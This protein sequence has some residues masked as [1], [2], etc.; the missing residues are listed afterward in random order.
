MSYDLQLQI[1]LQLDQGSASKLRR[2]IEN[3]LSGISVKGIDSKNFSK[4]NS[5]INETGKLLD[6]GAKKAE[7]FFDRVEGKARGF[8]AYAIAS[9]SII[10][11]TGA[12][13]S[14]TREAIKYETELLKIAQVTGDTIDRT[15][16]YSASLVDIST[17]YNVTLSKVAQLTRTLTQTGLSFKEASKGAEI[18]AR[19]SLLATFDSLTSTTEG[20][21]AVMQTFEFSVSRAG[22]VLE[23]INAVS[24]KFA[25][26]SGDIVEAIRRTGGAFSSAGGQIEELIALFTAVRSTSRETAETIA[27]GFRT[28]FGRLQRPKTIEFFKDLNIELQDLEGNFIGPYQAIER[29]SKGLEEA[30]IRAGSLRFAEVVEQIG[31]IRQ[32]SRVV[33]LLEEV[34]K[35][36][37]ALDIANNASIESIEDLEKAQAGL[38]FRLGQ[39]KQEFGALIAEIVNS[40]SLEFLADVFINISKSVIELTKALKP[41][42]PILSIIATYKIGRGLTSLLNSGI[43]KAKL[44]GY[45]SGG[46]VPGAGDRDTVPAMLT[47]GEFVIRKSAVKAFGANRLAGINKYAQG[48]PVTLDALSERQGKTTIKSSLNDIRQPKDKISAELDRQQIKFDGSSGIPWNDLVKEV[49]KIYKSQKSGNVFTAQGKAFETFIQKIAGGELAPNPD[50]PV[51]IIKNGKPI[52]VKFTKK[53]T[54]A[55]D[56]VSKLYRYQYFNNK[57]NQPNWT[58]KDGDDV[59]LGNLT[60]YEIGEGEKKKF[61]SWYS[62][63]KSSILKEKGSEAKKTKLTGNA[64]SY[65]H[66]RAHE[67]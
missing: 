67:T 54:D 30:G 24:K 61:D 15:K 35:S 19:T 52:E 18:L 2:Q 65:T 45:A 47:P 41:L 23:S 53:L 31:G 38:G 33:P 27:T 34:G 13:A 46:L 17:K 10:K 4:V 66:L 20:L 63:N 26:E 32:I 36:S 56:L 28:I 3:S 64:V 60:V 16:E 44:P 8:A 59:D 6:R 9:Q 57:L 58:E 51:D 42:L 5:H 12:I 11:L 29:I 43:G 7:S 39:L 22:K 50:Y 55:K 62:K 14:A 48:G 49:D 40:S 37:K 25:V 21:I 1:N